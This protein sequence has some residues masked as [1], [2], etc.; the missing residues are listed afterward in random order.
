MASND[1]Q[2]II[3]ENYAGEAGV[4]QAIWQL[5]NGSLVEDIPDAG[6][7]TSYVLSESINSLYPRVT[8]T[9]NGGGATEDNQNGTASS[10]LVDSLQ[11]DTGAYKPDLI[12]I[13]GNIYAV[14]YR[15]SSNQV[16]LKTFEILS[17]GS[18]SNSAI[19]TL[20]VDTTGYDTDMMRVSAS[21]VAVVYRGSSN[22]GCVATVGIDSNGQIDAAPIAT[23]VFSKKKCYEPHI[24]SING[25]YY[26]VVYRGPSD[27][28]YID[29]IRISSSGAILETQVST[30]NF[31]S[32]CFDPDIVFIAGTVYA[33]A[34]RGAN[35]AGF[36]ATV[37][38]SST[39]QISSSLIDSFEFDSAGGYV[40]D[41]VNIS[42][43][44]FAISY[45][46]PSQDG[47]MK[48]IEIG[49]GGQIGNTTIDSLEFDSGDSYKPVLV[50][51]SGT[52]YGIAYRGS[53]LNGKISTLNITPAGLISDSLVN[54]WEFDSANIYEPDMLLVTSNIL[55][56]AYRTSAGNGYLKTL[57]IAGAGDSDNGNTDT[58]PTYCIMSVAGDSKVTAVVTLSNGVPD[59]LSWSISRE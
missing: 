8:V 17:D 33:L 1:Y 46:E 2:E 19:D 45:R 23:D 25:E 54:S 29:T 59:I 37:A 38:I 49:T 35:Y 30:C 7:N 58:V 9:F 15:G 5:Q 43:S 12:N 32:T 34:Y 18:I 28:G 41:I 48:T 4:E 50:Q 51:V 27:K 47:Y 11:Y 10:D 40:P 53:G 57:N 13:T 6:D 21:M 22:K 24:I 31:T 26:A 56:V 44:I 42:G 3:D 52:V 16:I 14:T 39:G 20:T 36:L 55:A